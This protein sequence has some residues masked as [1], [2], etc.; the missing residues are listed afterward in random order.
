MD[1]FLETF[2]SDDWIKIEE[3]WKN[4]KI[5][6]R[7]CL[8]SQLKCVPPM[9]WSRTEAFLRTI[10]IDPFFEHFYRFTKAAGIPLTIVSDGLDRFIQ[11]I[12]GNG[13]LS[14]IPVFANRITPELEIS[15]PYAWEE[16]TSRAGLCKCRILGRKSRGAKCV[17]IGDG[18]SDFCV[19]KE[20]DYVFAK[21][22]LAAYCRDRGIP[23]YEFGDFRDVERKLALLLTGTNVVAK[24]RIQDH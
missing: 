12:L 5:G 9:P 1:S 7:E 18:Q 15:F 19:A 11:V 24:A 6:S 16:C 8:Y 2:A 17:Y 10:Q 14:E 23:F 13:E 20:P 3:D 4:G 21:K 22:S